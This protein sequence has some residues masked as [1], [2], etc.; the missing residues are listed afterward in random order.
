MCPPFLET[1]PPSGRKA[2]ETGLELAR[3]HLDLR[4]HPGLH[5]H[6]TKEENEAK[7]EVEPVCD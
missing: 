5:F 1:I 7:K 6:C 4:S 2:I 3:E